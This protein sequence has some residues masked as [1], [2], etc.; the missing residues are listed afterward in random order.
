[1]A[2]HEDAIP[3]EQAV[4]FVDL[5]RREEDRVPTRVQAAEK[6]AH[7]G[8]T[9]AVPGAE[10][11]DDGGA[12]VT[13]ERQVHRQHDLA[14]LRRVQGV[15][16]VL[17]VAGP[18][19]DEV[20]PTE[21]A[22]HIKEEPV[23]PPGTEHGALAQFVEAVDDKTVARAVQEQGRQEPGPRQVHGGVPGCRA[24]GRERAEV[25]EGLQ[26]TEGVALAVQFCEDLAVEARAVPGDLPPCLYLFRCELR[27]L[28]LR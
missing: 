25:T 1:M 27:V 21:E 18:E 14:V 24:G 10:R 9:D 2:D 6:P 17:G 3:A 13:L 4:P 23:E 28:Q 8:R 16:V 11:V 22:E 5:L 7:E 15:L 19:V 12:Q 20:V 26:H